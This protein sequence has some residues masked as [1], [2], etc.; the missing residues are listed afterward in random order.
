MKEVVRA[1]CPTCQNVLTIP[2][3]WADRTVKCKHCGHHVQAR[4][5]AKSEA[6]PQA[7]TGVPSAVPIA[8]QQ[9][10]RPAA[11]VTASPSWEPLPEYT[12]PAAAVPL[13]TMPAAPTAGP[14]ADKSTYVS[15]FDTRDKY[16]GRGNYKGPKSG[17]WIKYAV[18]GVLF[19]SLIGG[20]AAT[21]HY[22][23]DLFTRGPAEPTKDTA[24]AENKAGKSAGTGGESLTPAT[25][26][27]PRR[28]LAISIHNYLY[29]NPLHNGETN[30]A[31]EA[32]KTGTDA[33]VRKWAER[34]RVPNEQIYHLTD[35]PTVAE[36]LAAKQP[37]KKAD[38]DAPVVKSA[39]T[40]PLKM[41]MEGAVASFAESCR[42]QDR[43]VFVFCGHAYEKDGKAYLLPL[44]GDFEELDTL[45]PLEWFFEKV[46]A[47]KAQEKLVV[48]DVCRF[49]P[50]RGIERPH[51]GLMS[52]GLEKALHTAPD[53]VSVMTTCSKGEYSYELDYY[54]SRNLKAEIFGGF[55]L[56]M[57][58]AAS[59]GGILAPEGKLPAPAD[60]L[61][62]ERLAAF[63]AEKLPE[64]AKDRFGDKTQTPKITLKRGETAVAYNPSEAPPTKFAYV[65]PPPSADP[66]MIASILREIEVPSVKSFRDDAPPT[67][68]SDVIPFKK[69]TLAMYEVGAL[70]ADDTPND[71]QKVV[72]KA[73]EEMRTLRE[74]G[75]GNE[76]PESFVGESS[77]AAKNQL[78]R[79]QE[80]PA[81]VEVILREQLEELE[82]VAAMKEKE[83]KR[84]QAN[85]DY[86]LAQVKFRICYANQYNLALANFRGG[87][88]PDLSA[89][90]NGYR[91]TAETTLDKNT[92]KEYKTM[93]EEAKKSLNELV[94]AHPQTPWALLAK[95]D[96]SVAIGL[97]LTPSSIK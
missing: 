25:G 52:E 31:D 14:G 13:A 67:K 5:K 76:L 71:F 30:F 10:T 93:F 3:E 20:A 4:R 40:L 17:A 54:H 18:F 92:G 81:K 24:V 27:F 63:M 43:A 60:T 41:V 74:A 37:K 1:K 8:T 50:D 90:Q 22:R 97:R 69:E 73:V 68:V 59:I 83:T 55:F 21:Y 87:K 33:A 2:A 32:K 29:A 23:P 46:G 89:D 51:E 75:N 70:K 84:W 91:L 48:F 64:V 35:S 77:D 11:P 16:S 85:Y 94:K 56:S 47:C 15:A 72:V 82:N 42:E 39:K 78:K 80:V 19:L 7:R 61:P 45:I 58:H 96:R 66:K 95:A 53:G 88:V 86:I 38:K 34:W 79:V 36:K 44:E 28:M 49:H 9:P 57:I 62:V 65:M 12:P 26:V 6:A